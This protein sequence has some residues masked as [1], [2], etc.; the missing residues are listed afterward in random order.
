MLQLT[1]AVRPSQRCARM[2]FEALA[3]APS[4][5]RY[6]LGLSTRK[7]SGEQETSCCSQITTKHS[8]S[9]CDHKSERSNM[10]RQPIAS[11]Q[12]M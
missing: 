9:H 10:S 5:C 12:T 6:R 1:P 4:L 8:I 3:G 2:Q 7:L 11:R